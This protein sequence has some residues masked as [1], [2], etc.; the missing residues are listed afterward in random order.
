[1]D[2]LMSQTGDFVVA[3]N[4]VRQVA[5]VATRIAKERLAAP[6]VRA[7]D[8]APPRHGESAEI[9]FNRVEFGGGEL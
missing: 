5:T 3:S 8:V 4:Q 1:M 7:V 6:D 2:R 9:E